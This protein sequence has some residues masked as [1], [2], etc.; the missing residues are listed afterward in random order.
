M[1]S[2]FA[3]AHSTKCAE[4]ECWDEQCAALGEW[5][6]MVGGKWVV[7]IAIALTTKLA[8][9]NFFSLL[10]A[11]SSPLWRVIRRWSTVLRPLGCLAWS[12][13][14]AAVAVSR[15]YAAG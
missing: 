10:D 7:R 13:H 5:D 2:Y 11:E 4:Q 15:E 12:A 3:V 8:I 6:Q 9:R 1:L 14:I